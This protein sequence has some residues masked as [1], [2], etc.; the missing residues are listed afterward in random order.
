MFDIKSGWRVANRFRKN[1]TK[2]PACA[3]MAIGFAWYCTTASLLVHAE[4]ASFEQLLSMPLEDLMNIQLQVG[5]RTGDNRL[6]SHRVPVDVITA[7]EL[8]RSGYGDLPKALNHL[9]SSFT[10][11]Y[12]TLDD[13]TDHA[14][15][16][17]LNGLKADQVLVLINGK[18]VHQSAIIDVNDSQNRGSSSVDLS[19]I[20]IE[21]VARVEIL[22]DD[23]SSQYGSDAIAGVINV[24]LKTDSAN[25]LVTTIGQRE[26][27][28]GDLITSS[29]S[30]SSE[31]LFV[32]LE[33]KHKASSNTSG[34]DRRDYYFD[35]DARNGD[36]RV[37]HRYGDPAMETLSL[38]FNSQSF[39]G[40]PHAYAQGK[41]VYKESEASGFFRRPRDDRN[42]RAIYPDGFLPQLVPKQQ[43]I[44]T[45]IGYR[46]QGEGYSYDVSNS[47]GYNRVKINVENSLNASLGLNSPTDFDAGTLGFWHDSINFDATKLLS[48]PVSSPL[49]LAYGVELRREENRIDA[50][51]DAAWVDG[52]VAVLDGPNMGV[53]TVAGAQMYPGFSPQNA[54]RLSRNMLAVYAEAGH[55]FMDNAE[56][57]VSVRDEHYSDFGSTL[58]GKLLL[59]YDPNAK[60]SLR[61]S[62]SS[63]YRAPSLQQMG[64]YRT[65]TSFGPRPGG[66]V[67]GVENGIFPVDNEVARLLGATDLKPESS[68]RSNVGLTWQLFPSVQ[69]NLDYFHIAIADRIILSGD[70]NNGPSLPLAAQSYMLANQITFARYFLNAVDTKTEGFD[71]SIDYQA[72][73]AGGELLLNAQHHRHTTDIDALQIPDQLHVLAEQVFERSERERLIHYL[74]ETK[75][76]I[77]LTYKIN[78]WTLVAKA[79]YFGK[80]LYVASSDDHQSDQWFGARTTLDADLSKQI[81]PSLELAVGAHNIFNVFPEYRNTSAPFNGEGNILQYRGISPF[82]YTGAYYYARAT[83]S[84]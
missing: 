16:F 7:D 59:H 28:D 49:N 19:L 38:T 55:Y 78:D 61:S 31:A 79:N 72:S 3:A 33:Y 34:L 62:L 67:V 43:D 29:Y 51:E 25:E 46:D 66:G 14:R 82:D 50:G 70:I 53:D 75:S 40:D 23:A 65:A 2:V 84:F 17:S 42:V 37:T 52:L 8:R 11:D 74:P 13:L 80:V 24:V 15:P 5:A 63:G 56:V 35:G 73:L 44:F 30:Y 48:W 10:Y 22:K 60:L 32:S 20:P 71:V 54:K 68:A 6:G 21:A 69:F 9:I 47:F 58:N 1:K 26:A 76:L 41:L 4:D 57:R 36:H 39:F 77:S 27:G 81:S 45:T 64:Y 12:S 83:L 18:R